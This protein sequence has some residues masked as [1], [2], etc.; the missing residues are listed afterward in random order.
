MP[1]MFRAMKAGEEAN[2]FTYGNDSV[3]CRL[4]AG[5][6]VSCLVSDAPD[7]AV[8]AMEAD[9]WKRV[10]PVA[11]EPVPVVAPESPVKPSKPEPVP[12][13]VASP[14]SV[15]QPVVDTEDAVI[16]EDYKPEPLVVPAPSKP[17]RRAKKYGK[18]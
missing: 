4:G 15:S 1:T 13:A 9:G 3:G 8:A 7:S 18:R 5:K 16:V 14:V 17:K 12:E 6:L 10:V 2:P 11:V